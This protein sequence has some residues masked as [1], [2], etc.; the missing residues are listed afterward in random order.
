[1]S[2]VK[3]SLSSEEVSASV[4]VLPGASL[5]QPAPPGGGQQAGSTPPKPPAAAQF[6]RHGV[7]I[8]M[9]GTYLELLKYLEQVEALP[10][11]LAWTKIDLKTATYPQVELRATLHTV[12]PSPA[13]LTF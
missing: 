11:K 7:E 12:S 5:A 8:E 3:G 13:L 1:M 2:I 4:G 10:W 6:Y 9:T